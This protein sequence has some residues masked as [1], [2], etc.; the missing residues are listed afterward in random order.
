MRLSGRPPQPSLASVAPLLLGVRSALAH[1]CRICE[2]AEY[3]L[4]VVIEQP[5]VLHRPLWAVLCC[6]TTRTRLRLPHQLYLLSCIRD[7]TWEAEVRA[8]FDGNDAGCDASAPWGRRRSATSPVWD[9]SA[10]HGSDLVLSRQRG[11]AAFSR[12]VGG[13]AS[14]SRRPSISPAGVGPEPR[15][16]T[17]RPRRTP[18][19]P[20]GERGSRQSHD[21]RSRA[22]SGHRLL[23]LLTRAVECAARPLLYSAGP[24]LVPLE[25]CGACVL[26]RRG[27]VMP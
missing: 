27:R 25:R 5:V 19:Q 11:T 24:V 21:G 16:P 17:A 10:T 9:A 22:M 3:L 2:R 4:D 6:A 15:T 18:S 13:A 7:V 14:R 8:R 12:P 20:A 26:A 1:P 23:A